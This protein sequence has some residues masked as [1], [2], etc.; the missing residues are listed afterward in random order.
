MANYKVNW[1]KIKKY[2]GKDNIILIAKDVIWIEIGLMVSAIGTAFFYAAELGSNPVATLCDGMHSVLRISYGD[3]NTVA[4]LLLLAVLVLLDRRL[5]NIGTVLCVFTIGPWVNLFT[6][7]VFSLSV[8]SWS[9]TARVLSTVLGTV[10][11]GGGL[12]L[13]VAVDRG[14]GALEGLIKVLCDRCPK[15]SFTVAKIAQDVLLVAGGILLGAK[16]GVGTVIAVFLTGPTLQYSV[17]LFSKCRKA[18]RA[19][20]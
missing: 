2:T 3:A 9:M 6:P 5:V 15:I 12:G 13:Y 16:W 10:L 4:N 11:M 8:S 1:N 7:I 17:K 20:Q 14:Y 18:T 19:A